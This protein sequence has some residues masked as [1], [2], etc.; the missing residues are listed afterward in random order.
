MFEELTQDQ[1]ELIDHLMSDK[2]AFDL[3]V[4]TPWRE[5]LEEL[6]VRRSDSAITTYLERTLPVG[7]PEIMK[8]KKSMVLFRNIATPN[9]EMYRFMTGMD[10][11]QELHPVIFEYAEDKFADINENK[12]Y[13][14]KLCFH[15]GFNKLREPITIHRTII[16]MDKC[17]GKKLNELKTL[18]QEPFI[19]FHHNLFEKRLPAIQS[20]FFDIS[21]WISHSGK[22]PSI[23]YKYFLSL[24]LRH[25]ILFENFFIS[26]GEEEFTKKIILPA[27]LRLKSETGYKPLIIT[28]APTN[29]ETDCMWECYPRIKLDF[30]DRR[31]KSEFKSLVE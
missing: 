8:G 4:Y 3:F 21:E 28:L 27:I 5:A 12:F 2:K 22:E 10:V 13:L 24:F 17:N 31:M 11:L 9:Y 1:K 18:W 25:G 29:S 7:V 26:N 19:D 20:S 23:Y 16:Q 14:G 15:T 6:D 30:V